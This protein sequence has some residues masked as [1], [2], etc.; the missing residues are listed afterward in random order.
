M[1]EPYF[2]KKDLADTVID[3]GWFRK[4]WIKTFGK[5]YVAI[6]FTMGNHVICT[7]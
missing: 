7:S 3:I 5:K 1:E 4:L 6:D 2:H